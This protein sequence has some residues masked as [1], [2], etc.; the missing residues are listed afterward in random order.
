MIFYFS[1]TGNNQYI[2]ERIAGKTG[3][4][5]ISIREAVDQNHVEVTLADEENLGFVI[6]TYFGGF[7]E[8]V[9]TFLDSLHVKYAQNNYIFF[10]ATYG[11]ATGNIGL[12]AKDKI[13]ALGQSLDASFSVKMV[14]NWNPGFDMTDQAYIHR[15]EE[16]AEEQIPHVLEAITRKEH[17]LEIGK[18]VLALLQ[19]QARKM[20]ERARRTDN[21]SVG[22]ECIHC[23]ICEK[24]CPS[25]AIRLLIFF[26]ISVS[27]I[28]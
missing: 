11:S 4:R 14:D 10:V 17:C 22:C 23:G 15:A 20:Y 24:Q 13:G 28:F 1:A 26:V 25:H 27:F 9:T 7:P 2:A 19:N 21:F 12:E 3:D 8:I 6:P 18:T 16:K 5:I